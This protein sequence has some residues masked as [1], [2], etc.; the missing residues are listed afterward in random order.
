MKRLILILLLISSLTAK[1]SVYKTN[2]YESIGLGACIVSAI[3]A[4]P[5]LYY[6]YHPDRNIGG[7]YISQQADIKMVTQGNYDVRA[8]I[9]G[10][11]A[12]I[13]PAMTYEWF[14]EIGYESLSLGLNYVL[15]DRKVSLLPGIEYSCIYRYKPFKNINVNSAGINVEFRYLTSNRLSFSYISNIKTRP[16]ISKP[17]VYSGYISINFRLTK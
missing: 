7:L 14:P 10:N 15:I 8:R 16:E 4:Y 12:N 2:T 1:S 11:I 17:V 6:Y 9:F 5:I 3:A 13:E